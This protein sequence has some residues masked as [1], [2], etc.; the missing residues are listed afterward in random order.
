MQFNRTL[1]R[2]FPRAALAV[3]L[4]GSVLISG[5]A[6]PAGAATGIISTYAGGTGVGAATA[7]GMTPEAVAIIGC[8]VFT[9]GDG[10]IRVIDTGTG[11]QTVV[12]GNGNPEYVGDGG[13]ASM[14]V[15]R[16]AR[17]AHDRRRRKHLRQRHRALRRPPRRSQR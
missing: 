10:T 14:P 1:T 13:P 15:W 2:R 3:S 12:A 9:A 8:Q 6:Q 16:V 4:L 7:V 5:T 11:T 17:R